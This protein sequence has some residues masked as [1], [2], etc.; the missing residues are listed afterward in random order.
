VA[1]VDDDVR[2][3]VG[4][5]AELLELEERRAARHPDFTAADGSVFRYPR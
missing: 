3:T 4:L 2:V 5:Y 1:R